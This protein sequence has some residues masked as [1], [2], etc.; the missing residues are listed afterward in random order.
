[1]QNSAIS[2]TIC[3]DDNPTKREQLRSALQ[4]EFMIYY[5][6]GLDMIT[7]KNSNYIKVDSDDHEKI[8]FKKELVANKKPLVELEKQKRGL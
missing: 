1:M 2:F 7:I 6:E 8:I 3:I 5:N 4:D